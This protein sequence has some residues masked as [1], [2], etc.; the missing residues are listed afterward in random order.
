LRSDHDPPFS[1]LQANK[2]S[3]FD[4][5]LA[6][7]VGERLGQPLAVQWFTTS[8]DPDHDPVTEADALLADGRCALLADYPLLADKLGRPRAPTGKLPPFV[9]AKPEDR[10]RWIELGELVPTRPYRFDAITVALS[11]AQ[12][13]RP[14]HGLADLQGLAL[15][16]QIHGLPDLIAMSYHQSELAPNVVHFDQA[17]MLFSKLE[18]GDI[19]AALVDQ[20]A[21]DAWRFAHPETRVMATG[22]QHSI[23]FNIGFVGLSG[24]DALIQAVDRIL[25]SLL[26]DGGLRKLAQENGVTYRAPHKPDVS[27]GLDLSAV[28]GD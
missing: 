26:G 2:P 27:P 21:L 24:S 6:G 18:S 3:G 17:R 16:V 10:R 13:R 23:G 7:L 1:F 19:G 14:V 8:D 22:Y 25:D 11:P 9:G 5:A 28:T 15:G 20:R 12:S 4:A